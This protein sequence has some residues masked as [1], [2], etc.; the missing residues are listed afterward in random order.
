MGDGQACDL[1]CFIWRASETSQYFVHAR[2]AL[3]AQVL[4]D[5][6]RYFHGELETSLYGDLSESELLEVMMDR[7]R[8]AHPD[9]NI[10]AGV[11]AWMKNWGSDSLFY[12]AYVDYAPGV[13]WSGKWK[14]S[15]KRHGKMVVQF[16][17]EAAC[18]SMDGYTHGAL[19]S[20]VQ[21]AANYLYQIG[22]G[23][24]PSTDDALSLCDWSDSD[25]E[26]VVV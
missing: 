23:P 13:S 22:Q 7:L 17:G 8:R 25:A 11:A 10:P 3:E 5:E 12:G 2:S 14:K 1:H 20:G 4:F 6:Q 9:K 18:S 26:T 15:L 24:D 19:Y 21:A 16:A